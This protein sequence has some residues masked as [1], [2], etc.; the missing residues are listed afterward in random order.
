MARRPL[1]YFHARWFDPEEVLCIPVA[2]Y[3]DGADLLPGF[4]FSLFCLLFWG[5]SRSATSS[6]FGHLECTGRSILADGVFWSW[7][8][9]SCK[10]WLDKVCILSFLI[11]ISGKPVTMIWRGTLLVSYLHYLHSSLS[12][13]GWLS[14]FDLMLCYGRKDS[15]STGISSWRIVGRRFGQTLSVL[16]GATVLRSDAL[17]AG[18]SV[19]WYCRLEPFMGVMFYFP[20]CEM[21]GKC[22]LDSVRHLNHRCDT[23]VPG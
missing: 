9:L 10:F 11:P 13:A 20:L 22:R 14:T 18:I 23:L 7:W 2:V 12:R 1:L 16:N 6:D 4:L 19:R 8:L 5:L 15:Y 3:V 17:L 21:T